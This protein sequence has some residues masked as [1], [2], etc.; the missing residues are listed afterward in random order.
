MAINDYL[1]TSG[2]FQDPY[3]DFVASFSLNPHQF[4]PTERLIDRCTTGKR[5]LNKRRFQPCV[6]ELAMI[7]ACTGNCDTSTTVFDT[8]RLSV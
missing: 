8:H 1:Q 5:Q 4:A 2:R 7:P 3:E 6:K